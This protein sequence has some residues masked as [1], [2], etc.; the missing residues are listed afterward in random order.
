M[1]IN[2][3]SR[4]TRRKKTKRNNN[5]RRNNIRRNNT[6]RNNIRRNNIRYTNS[7]RYTRK[8]NASRYKIK[9][10]GVKMFRRSSS[11]KSLDTEV[12]Q[13][14]LPPIE[15]LQ[16]ALKT[17]DVSKCVEIVLESGSVTYAPVDR[18]LLYK[19]IDIIK[20]TEGVK[21]MEEISAGLR[22][23]SENIEI[24]GIYQNKE[25]FEKEHGVENMK[26]HLNKK[27]MMA[28]E[29]VINARRVEK[30]P[31]ISESKLD[32]IARRPGDVYFQ[33]FYKLLLTNIMRDKLI[34]QQGLFSTAFFSL[35][36]EQL[37]DT[38]VK[39]P[40]LSTPNLSDEDKQKVLD[41]YCL[42]DNNVN[43]LTDIEQLH[44]IPNHTVQTRV[45][46]D[47][48]QQIQS[49]IMNNDDAC[50][51]ALVASV[52]DLGI[53]EEIHTLLEADPASN[54]YDWIQGSKWFE[55]ARGAGVHGTKLQ[56]T[57]DRKPYDIAARLLSKK[58]IDLWNR[59]LTSE[60]ADQIKTIEG[61]LDDVTPPN[62]EILRSIQT[63]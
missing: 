30:L 36:K 60:Q 19:H 54:I 11:T 47:N 38:I 39:F 59:A 61:V 34:Q 20:E 25:Y 53:I 4:K 44:L 12:L 58:Y 10:G 57:Y 27:K 3:I 13:E 2:K 33:E 42:Q 52:A 49:Y 7:K 21:L 32:Q 17:I 48:L 26:R 37:R 18:Y 46:L 8:R 6:R 15:V 28:L 16:K 23:V 56:F 5:T 9:R 55:N 29:G 50:M 14:V 41:Y 40:Y 43:I 62:A 24:Q 63:S 35:V 1:V 51:Q 31:V 22:Q 45:I